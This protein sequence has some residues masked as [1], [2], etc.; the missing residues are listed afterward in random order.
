VFESDEFKRY[1]KKA[2][3]EYIDG[4]KIIHAF[5][6]FRIYLLYDSNAAGGSSMLVHFLY[7]YRLF[8]FSDSKDINE[9][10]IYGCVSI[11]DT[12]E[13]LKVPASGSFNFTSPE[14]LAKSNLQNIVISSSRSYKKLNSGIFSETL[15]KIGI[16]VFRINESGAV[17][18]ETDGKTTER[19]R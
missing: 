3:I 11:E 19:V 12:T 13:I 2:N 7:G 6:E 18:F 17:I 10:Y 4:S 14:Y 5:P 16:N 9:E 1:F 15:E 8:T